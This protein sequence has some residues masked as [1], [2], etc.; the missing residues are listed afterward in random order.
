MSKK[1]RYELD[2]DIGDFVC[3]V[4]DPDYETPS[5]VKKIIL[6]R[7]EAI[8]V[9]GRGIEEMECFGFELMEAKL[10]A[11]NENED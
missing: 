8:Y 4:T 9:V 11:Q 5:I 6:T 7:K 3:F 2:F 10:P 1:V